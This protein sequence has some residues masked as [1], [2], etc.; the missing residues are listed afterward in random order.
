[1]LGALKSGARLFVSC[2]GWAL[3]RM[4]RMDCAGAVGHRP[5]WELPQDLAIESVR[6]RLGRGPLPPGAGPPSWT[7]SAG[8]VRL[9]AGPGRSG[10][11]VLRTGSDIGLAF[12]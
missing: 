5:P 12:S 4:T 2:P 11:A 1:M 3:G 10:E 7:R 8:R 9:T 6:A